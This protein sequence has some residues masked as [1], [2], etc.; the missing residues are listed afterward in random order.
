V[1]GA[2]CVE[3]PTQ[4]QGRQEAWVEPIV[5]KQAKT[6]SYRIRHGGTKAEIGSKGRDQGGSRCEFPLPHVKYSDPPDYAEKQWALPGKMGQTLIAIVAEGN[7][8]RACRADGAHETLALAAK[9]IGSRNQ[10]AERSLISGPWTTASRPSVIYSLI[11][12]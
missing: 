7:R 10:P 2:D 5:D 8:S 12:S 1:A 6:I 4:H 3:L 9:P 11:A